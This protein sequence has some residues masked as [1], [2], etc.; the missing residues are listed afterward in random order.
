MQDVNINDKGKGK[1]E[2]EES[3]NRRRSKDSDRTGDP[4][5]QNAV[6]QPTELRLLLMIVG[7]NR[8]LKSTVCALYLT[9]ELT[10]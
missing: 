8:N 6:H 7:Q 3:R 10:K 5:A 9:S 2:T 1:A 4:P